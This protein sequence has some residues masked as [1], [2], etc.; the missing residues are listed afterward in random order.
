MSSAPCWLSKSSALQC[1]RLRLRVGAMATIYFYI[2]I[3]I[4]SRNPPHPA[5][6]VLVHSVTEHVALEVT[7]SL[8]SQSSGLLRLAGSVGTRQPLTTSLLFLISGLSSSPKL[9]F[10]SMHVS[11]S[12]FLS[13]PLH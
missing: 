1:L 3:L 6:F 11:C 2:L 13:F 4:R 9:R 12:T 7:S 10:A 5:I 8:L